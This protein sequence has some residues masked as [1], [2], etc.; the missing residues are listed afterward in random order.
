MQELRVD[1]D[2]PTFNILTES[3]YHS[4]IKHRK[5]IKKITKFINQSNKDVAECMHDQLYFNMDIVEKMNGIFTIIS[6]NKGKYVIV[7]DKTTAELMRKCIVYLIYKISM[8][9]KKIEKLYSTISDTNMMI[10]AETKKALYAVKSKFC[11][12][13]YA[14]LFQ[15]H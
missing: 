13:L 9:S 14:H 10:K 15:M 8:K 1:L 7:H 2:D 3:L 11:E 12:E 6:Q 5:K 4:I